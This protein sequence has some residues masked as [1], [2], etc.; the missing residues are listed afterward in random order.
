MCQASSIHFDLNFHSFITL[1][2]DV[3]ITFIHET[4]L[5]Y[6][7]ILCSFKEIPTNYGICQW[8]TIIYQWKSHP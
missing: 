2:Q 5:I 4:V 6:K 3:V 7:M 1:S 8:P